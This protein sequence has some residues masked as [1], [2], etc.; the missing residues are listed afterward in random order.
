[1]IYFYSHHR[2][3][4]TLSPDTLKDLGRVESLQKYVRQSDYTFYTILIDI[5]IPDVLR[6][7]PSKL[8]ICYSQ[9]AGLFISRSI[10]MGSA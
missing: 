8:L 6:P 3:V 1:M 4:E 9:L 10:H 7:I 2:E 5:L